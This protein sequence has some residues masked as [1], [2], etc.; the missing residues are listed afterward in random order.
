MGIV[1]GILCSDL[2]A[3]INKSSLNVGL[4]QSTTSFMLGL[5]FISKRI[6]IMFPKKI[7]ISR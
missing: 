6:K 4:M 2:I 5:I 1:V 3:R 7:A